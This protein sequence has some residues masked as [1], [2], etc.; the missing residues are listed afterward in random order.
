MIPSPLTSDQIRYIFSSQP[1]RLDE[2]L[3]HRRHLYRE[4]A[5][6]GGPVAARA[7]EIL[8][9]GG[10]AYRSELRRRLRSVRVRDSEL[11]KIDRL[12]RGQLE[13]VV[14]GARH[15]RSILFFGTDEVVAADMRR[16]GL[17]RILESDHLFEQRFV[18]A[19]ADGAVGLSRPRRAVPP[20]VRNAERVTDT[21][22]LA[23]PKNELFYYELSRRLGRVDGGFRLAGLYPHTGPGSK[24]THL[25]RLIQPGAEGAFSVFDH[26]DAHR[27]V[28]FTE[29]GLP[30]SPFEG[31]IIRDIAHAL[32]EGMEQS[33]SLRRQLRRATGTSQPS[34]ADIM[35][36]LRQRPRPT[37]ASFAPDRWP[38][39]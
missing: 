22:A 23:V 36:L 18:D 11:Q 3:S 37:A 13:D 31:Y 27:W 10:R 33:A 6:V 12:F 24:T 21:Y 34:V 29:M 38:H 8:G 17:S 16:L 25:A 15:S 2:I 19:V 20:T 32:E 26:L 9:P 14:D 30:R 39:F 28:L 4:L 7:D 35:R 1:S 5:R